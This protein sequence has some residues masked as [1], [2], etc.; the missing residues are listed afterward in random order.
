MSQI[1]GCQTKNTLKFT[2]HV[3]INPT[4]EKTH[5]FGF[6]R[7]DDSPLFLSIYADDILTSMYINDN[8]FT[9]ILNIDV[10]TM[11][12]EFL[13]WSVIYRPRPHFCQCTAGYEYSGNREED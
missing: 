9:K 2:G 8:K 1:Y 6:N 7:E 5:G 13:L 4:G 3:I 10:L 11:V 12:L